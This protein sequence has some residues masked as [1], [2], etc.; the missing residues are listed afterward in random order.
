MP[1]TSLRFL[2]DSW[3]MRRRSY[4]NPALTTVQPPPLLYADSSTNPDQRYFGRIQI[5]DPFVSFLAGR[6]K[7]EAEHDLRTAR[8]A[9]RELFA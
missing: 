9:Y 3:V 5:P 2:L 1:K 7:V 8:Q 6:R 4:F